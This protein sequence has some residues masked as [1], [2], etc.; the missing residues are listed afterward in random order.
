[1]KKL[2][3]KHMKNY[4]FISGVLAHLF[5][6]VVFLFQPVLLDK[7]TSKV[8]SK[9]YAWQKSKEYKAFTQGGTETISSEI[10][11]VFID[12]QAKVSTKKISQNFEVN[13]IGF[14][15][16][17]EAVKALQHGDELFIAAGTYNTPIVITKN[18]ITIK[19]L[20]HVIFE[21]GVSHGKGFLLNKGNNLTVV[22]I[23]CRGI[24]TRDGNGACIRQEGVNLTLDHVYFHS[25]QEGVLETA[26]QAGVVKILNSRFEGLGHN[27]QAHGVYTNKA[28]LFIENSLFITTKNQGHALKVRG[29]NLTINSSILASLSADDSRLIDMPNGGELIVTSSLLAQGPNS[30]NG[31]MIGYGF[32][33]LLHPENAINLTNNII[34]LER[35]G[36]NY[37]L[38][39]PQGQQVPNIIQ[40]NNRVIGEDNSVYH[41]ESNVYFTDR[42]EIGLP[43]YPYLPV[44]FCE[45]RD[46]CPIK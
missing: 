11:R 28:E 19:G 27:G 4:L 14:T 29:R 36:N 8:T 42:A 20:G 23:E 40:H 30:V 3:K 2:I 37:L 9:Y 33:E 41:D 22:N 39:L 45:Q 12:W 43:Q 17:Q 21:E 7:L 38:G 15:H 32:K 25:S 18:N 31:Q 1:M 34:Y 13:S 35:L 10:K 26:R 46:D 6:V 24:N 16:I 5:V 44:S